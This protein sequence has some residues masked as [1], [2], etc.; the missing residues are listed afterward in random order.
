MAG[1][2]LGVTDKVGETIYD[3]SF[4]LQ[5]RPNT[6]VRGLNLGGLDMN[7]QMSAV[8]RPRD[9]LDAGMRRHPS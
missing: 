6:N 3:R 8:N 9:H 5:D 1:S 7:R 4:M 2:E